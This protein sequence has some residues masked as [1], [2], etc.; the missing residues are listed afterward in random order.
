MTSFP[1]SSPRFPPPCASRPAPT[2]RRRARRRGVET[3]YAAGD[4]V[5]GIAAGGVGPDSQVATA[6][7]IGSNARGD[8]QLALL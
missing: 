1:A 7:L 4:A 8:S 6:Q 5:R 2:P 3:P